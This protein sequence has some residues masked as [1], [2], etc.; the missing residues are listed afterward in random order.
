MSALIDIA[1]VGCGLIGRKRANA[2]AGARLVFACDVER[3]RAES[4]AAIVPGCR[5]TADLG[6]VLASSAQAVVVATRQ[7]RAGAARARGGSG[8]ETRAHRETRRDPGE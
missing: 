4:L 7:P 2:L 1:I 8:G 6:E 5:A 3:A